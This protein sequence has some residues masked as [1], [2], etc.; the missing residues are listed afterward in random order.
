MIRGLTILLGF[1]LFGEVL[2]RGLGLG[3]PGPVIGLAGLAAALMLAARQGVF[4]LG[5]VEATDVGKAAVTLL[6]V[7]GVLFV[8]AGV[9][10]MQ[11]YRLLLEHGLA[12][13][14]VLVLSTVLT[15]V[16]TVWTFVGV[17]RLVAGRS[18]PRDG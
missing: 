17:K 11:Q 14:A 7:L 9:G 5:A 15:L 12:L 18:E 3:V 1:Q 4:G 2:A 16:A 10:I 6:G 13:L 8:P